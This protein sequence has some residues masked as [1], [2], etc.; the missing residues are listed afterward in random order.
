MTDKLINLDYFVVRL[1]IEK[2]CYLLKTLRWF[3]FKYN[4]LL[5][6]VFGKCSI[7]DKALLIGK[8]KICTSFTFGTMHRF[9]HKLNFTFW[10]AEVNSHKKD[11][12]QPF[13][14]TF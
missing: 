6:G 7:S 2:H 8:G 5:Q 1:F 11:R 4:T 13:Q 10:S 14:P 9:A 3:T 12:Y